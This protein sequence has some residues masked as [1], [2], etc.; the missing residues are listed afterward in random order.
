MTILV[1]SRHETLAITLSQPGDYYFPAHRGKRFR[2][3]IALVI[4]L[5]FR[6]EYRFEMKK[7]RRLLELPSVD[8]FC[9]YRCD[10][11]DE[12]SM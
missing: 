1:W 3:A 10:T 7:D 8:T 12:I 2:R 5:A 6:V 11:E 4:N 9:W